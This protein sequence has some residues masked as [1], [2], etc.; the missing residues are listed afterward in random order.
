MITAH[1]GRSQTLRIRIQ[2]GCY[3]PGS[4]ENADLFDA[5]LGFPIENHPFP[6]P[7]Y[8]YPAQIAQQRVAET[9]W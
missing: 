9:A 5:V 4:V 6:K 1:A 7:A 8:R 2:N 3:I